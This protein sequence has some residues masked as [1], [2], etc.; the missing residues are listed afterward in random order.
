MPPTHNDLGRS[1]IGPRRGGGRLV[2]MIK[3]Y[4]GDRLVS[5]PPFH[6]IIFLLQELI[7]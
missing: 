3:Y 2:V 7:K 4:T 1:Q 5:L 6:I